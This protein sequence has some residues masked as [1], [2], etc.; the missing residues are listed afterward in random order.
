[1]R[2]H[3]RVV[4]T[5]MAPLILVMYTLLVTLSTIIVI[6]FLI[7]GRY[8]TFY[9]VYF[10]ELFGEWIRI[11]VPRPLGRWFVPLLPFYTL[12]RVYVVPGTMFSSFTWSLLG[13]L[14]IE[15]HSVC[16]HRE[17]W[18]AAFEPQWIPQD[19]CPLG[20]RP[21]RLEDRRL[22]HLLLTLTVYALPLLITGIYVPISYSCQCAITSLFIMRYVEYARADFEACI[23]WNMHCKTLTLDNQ[24]RLTRAWEILMDYVVGPL[25]GYVPRVYNANHLLAHHRDNSGP[26]D[27]HSPTPFRRSSLLEFCFFAMKLTGSIMFGT[28]LVFHRRC[29]GKTRTYLLTNLVAFWS[30]VTV[31][32]AYSSLLAPIIMFFAIHHGV[33]MARFQYIWHGL[34]D[35]AKPE[36]LITSTTL[37]VSS[38]QFWLDTINETSTLNRSAAV[39]SSEIDE[40]PQPGTDWAFFDNYH[41]IHHLKPAAH[42]TQYPSLLSR[43]AHEIVTAQ[44]VVLTLDR[45][46]TFAFD[47]W[48]SNIDRIISGL[49]ID[50]SDDEKRAFIR[51][52]LQPTLEKRHRI[53]A[54]CE[55]EVARLIEQKL[56]KVLEVVTGGQ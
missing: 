14:L 12:T 24:P 2:A 11:L 37:W 31:L 9:D 40:V 19:A 45:I 15:V 3:E 39:R 48:A 56:L 8:C 17:S 4:G 43:N 47:C 32:F 25:N 6:P 38:K 16:L 28:D 5:Y 54:V 55:S 21:R 49:Q 53:A 35:P 10:N 33:S 46:A 23:H 20:G 27:I 34:I 44:S 36:Q 50:L 52:R 18:I 22:H 1:M 13:I 29:S 30:S 41:L 26:M 42:F 7:V 51:A